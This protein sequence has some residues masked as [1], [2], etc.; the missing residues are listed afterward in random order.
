[1]HQ[2]R[3]AAL[4]AAARCGAPLVVATFC[5]SELGD[6]PQ[7]AEFEAL[8][9]LSTPARSRSATSCWSGRNW[10]WCNN[11]QNSPSSVV[12]SCSQPLHN[13]Q[14]KRRSASFPGSGSA[15]ARRSQRWAEVRR[16]SRLEEAR[17]GAKLQQ[18]LSLLWQIERSLGQAY[19]KQKRLEEA[20]QAF[21]AVRQGI[22]T[23]A[24]SI[25]DPALREH[26][27]QAAYATLPKGKAV[28]QRR[29]MTSQYY[30]DLSFRIGGGIHHYRIAISAH[31]SRYPAL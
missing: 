9:Q 24:E 11:S 20:Q 10:P 29:A 26:F 30:G 18:Y 1:M 21:A 25:E 22:A 15:R 17:R 13:E 28:S 27:E 2:V 23:L 3:L 8:M 12:S 14:E 7:F 5:Y 31:K 4:G 19:Q 16:R 6:R